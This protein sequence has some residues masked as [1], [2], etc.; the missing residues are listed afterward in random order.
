MNPVLSMLHSQ[1]SN[2]KQSFAQFAKSMQ[3]K[4]P[5]AMVDELR[6]SGQMS[7]QQYQNLLRQAQSICSSDTSIRRFLNLE[8]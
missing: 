1:K 3:G 5:K 6:S 2:Q 4:D 8:R 7:E